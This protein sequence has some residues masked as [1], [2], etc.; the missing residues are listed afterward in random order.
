MQ[1]ANTLI[2]TVGKCG[3]RHFAGSSD[4]ARFFLDFGGRVW[5]WSWKTDRVL[6][7]RLDWS[8]AGH[9]LHSLLMRLRRYIMK[10]E[11]LTTLP[12]IYEPDAQA[13]VTAKALE[14]GI[15]TD[16]GKRHA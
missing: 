7:T 15:L 14:L 11:Q 3:Y 1:R 5:W 9:T 4:V 6:T 13:T 10:G 2:E 8:G 12:E 16:K